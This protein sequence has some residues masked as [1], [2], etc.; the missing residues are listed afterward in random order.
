M[1]ESIERILV[2]MDPT[3]DEQ[4]ALMQA[5]NIAK[6]YGAS[7]EIFLA[8]RN[9][10]ILSHWPLTEGQ[11]EEVISHFLKAR[12]RWLESYVAEVAAMGI[13]ISIDAVWEAPVYQAVIHKLQRSNFDLVVKSTHVHPTLSKMFFMPNDWQLMK[14]CPA[15]LLL[16]RQPVQPYETIMACVDP[17]NTNESHHGLDERILQTS[18]MFAENFRGTCHAAHCWHTVPEDLW[19]GLW[20]GEPQ[21]GIAGLKYDTYF[22]GVEKRHQEQFDKLLKHQPIDMDKRHLL[23]GDPNPLLTDIAATKNVDLM[24]IGSQYKT[25]FMGTTMEVLLDKLSCDV[26]VL[27]PEGFQTPVH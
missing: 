6:K 10:S 20:V 3:T 25:G 18:V 19:Q 5:I 22:K 21:M 13:P 4:P 14:A 27:K 11:E 1:L 8:E 26:L 9:D 12:R 23:H 7:I 17:M 24:V 15:P 16:T 2:D